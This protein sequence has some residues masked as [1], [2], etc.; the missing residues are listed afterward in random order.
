VRKARRLGAALEAFAAQVYFA[1]ECHAEYEALGFGP[2]PG[3]T[4]GGVALPD[5]AA[6]FCSRGSSMGQ[7]PGEVVAAAFAVFNPVAVVAA[8]D[9]GWSL[10]DAA[11]ISTARTRGAVAHLERLLG[12]EPARLTEVTALLQR[13]VD[14]LR[15]EGKPLFAGLSSLP[16]PGSPLGDAWRL[17]DLLREY[18][19]DAHTAAWTAAGFDACEIGLVTELYWGLPM[20][21]YVRTRAWS[22]SDLDA[23]EA[24][25]RARGLLD[26]AGLSDAGRE[27]RE[28][29]EAATDRQCD[30]IVDAL[31]DDVDT[32]V[33]VIGG[34]SAT[35]RDAKGYLPTGPHELAGRG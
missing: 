26:G 5:G 28:L 31:A 20:R 32:V 10:T 34:W 1:P 13:A 2:S 33:D 19:G 25:L 27:A 35:I 17:A 6:Y 9:H 23:A 12:P 15:P 29:V 16:L 11:T 4:S 14:P 8:V 22:P 30:V 21:T 7:V 24:R 3:S 18:R